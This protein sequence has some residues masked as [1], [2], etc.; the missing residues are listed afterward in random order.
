M[1]VFSRTVVA[2]AAAACFT[3]T[4]AACGNS[5][6]GDSGGDIALDSDTQRFGYAIGL[7]VGE[8]LATVRDDV[9]LA[10][11]KAG[12][13]DA[14]NEREA[15]LD[16]ATRDA[17]KTEAAER[18]QAKQMEGMMQKAAA[19]EEAGAKFLADNAERD[20]VTVTESGL[21]YEV[22]SEGEGDKPAAEDTVTVHY[23][24]T[25]IDGT[26][27][28]SSYARNEPV[29]FPLANVIAGWTEGLQLMSPGAKYKL[30]IPAAL[31]YGER[32]AGNR[33]GPNETL[34]FEVELLSVAEADN[35]N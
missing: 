22:L 23:R 21:Q 28:D 34:V 14:F 33:I 16:A 20:G 19:A 1:A 3:L 7:D 26:E 31:G 15:R 17:I 10:A 29:S 25:L 32:G 18:I 35:S 5:G 24:G 9:D 8:S 30:F 6:S 4:L 11:I 27:F 13:D 2:A 12:L